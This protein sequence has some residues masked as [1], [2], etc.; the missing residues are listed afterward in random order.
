MS[1]ALLALLCC[2]AARAAVVDA[3]AATVGNEVILM[4]EVIEDVEPLAAELRQQAAS[5]AAF[6]AEM[7]R[8]MQEALDQ[9]IEFK[10]LFRQAQLAGLQ[11]EDALIEQRLDEV[12]KRYP[13]EAAFQDALREAGETMS[14]IRDRLRKQTMAIGMGYQKRRQLEQA[15]TI[16][17]ADVEQ[18][19]RDNLETFRRKE[20]VLLRRIFLGATTPETRATARA[21][22]EV[23]REE[24]ALG[25]NF[26]E[27]ARQHSE[28]PE[29]EADGRVGWVERGDLVVAL[30]D[31]AF[32]LSPGQ[33]SAIVDTEFGCVLLAVDEREEEGIASLD[34]VRT[35]IEPLLRARGADEQYRNWIAELRQRSRVRVFL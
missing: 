14:D 11:I 12:R 19:Y 1:L 7:R 3:I 22:L 8:A 17:Q 32:A 24:L 20:R 9:A 15:V 23:L 34:E 13:N 25:A 27:L 29:A 31:A 5:S 2:A 28:G 6:D 21:R 18:Y 33:T 30:E 10:I 16:S 35:E 4:S 26:G